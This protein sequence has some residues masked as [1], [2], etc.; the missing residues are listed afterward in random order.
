MNV[1]APFLFRVMQ[2]LG[3]ARKRPA[4]YFSPLTPEYA[5]AWL[6]GVQIACEAA[7]IERSPALEEEA[8]RARGIEFDAAGPIPKLKAL[9]HPPEKIIDELIA[10]QIDVWASIAQSS[11]ESVAGP[12]LAPAGL[13]DERAADRETIDRVRTQVAFHLRWRPV[14]I[15]LAAGFILLLVGLAITVAFRVVG[16]RSGLLPGLE[17]GMIA[18][19]FLGLVTGLGLVKLGWQIRAA[20]RGVPRTHQLLLRYHEQLRPAN[21]PPSLRKD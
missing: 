11:P 2:I 17:K 16:P 9:G 12:A 8:A 4:M 6:H 10:L 15:A 7:G 1:A 21:K 5:A 3:N 20:L 14:I 18:G 13:D 19:G